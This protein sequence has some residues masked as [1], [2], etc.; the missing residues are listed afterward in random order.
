MQDGSLIRTLPTLTDDEGI[1]SFS[2]DGRLLAV[3]GNPA[4]NQVVWLRSSDGRPQVTLPKVGDKN[5][6]GAWSPDGTLFG[7]TEFH[8][9]TSGIIE[10]HWLDWLT[11]PGWVT[12]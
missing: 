9:S 3:A 2:P 6:D 7:M 5:L 4:A 10:I 11:P 1:L 8:P 12:L